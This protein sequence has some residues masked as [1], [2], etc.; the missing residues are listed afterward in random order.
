MDNIKAQQL[1]AM[2]VK[3]RAEA[4]NFMRHSPSTMDYFEKLASKYE[5]MAHEVQSSILK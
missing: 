3:Y 4:E 1:R 5:A 2:A